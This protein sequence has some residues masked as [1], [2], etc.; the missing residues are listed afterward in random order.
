MGEVLAD[1]PAQRER[2]G[3][4]GRGRG[5]ADLVDEVGLDPTHQIDGRVENRAPRRKAVGGVGANFR[6]ERDLPAREQ[7]MRGRATR[8][9]CAG[10]RSP[11]WA[12]A[13]DNLSAS[14]ATGESGKGIL[15]DF[16]AAP[17]RGPHLPLELVS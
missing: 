2:H 11:P 15:R 5:C 10:C 13:S 17:G 14:T 12:L 8:R 9:A 4:R 6:I 3:R 1:A 7:V 16:N